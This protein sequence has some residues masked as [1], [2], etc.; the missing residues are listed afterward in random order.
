M[1]K[2]TRA[3][4]FAMV[5]LLAAGLT[6]QVPALAAVPFRYTPPTP[7]VLPSIP[8]GKAPAHPARPADP[9]AAAALTRA[10]AVAWPAAGSPAARVQVLDHA[11]AVAAHQ[12][13]LLR[14]GP[15]A[16]ASATAAPV[17]VSVDY[18]TFQHAYGADWSTRLRLVQ[19][20]ECA[21]TTPQAAGC[22]PKPLASSNNTK[23]HTVSAD[24]AA[25]PNTLLAVTAG[26]S[27]SAGDF[28]VTALAASS[29]WQAGGSSGD[30]TWSYP[31]RV[32]PPPAGPAPQVSLSYSAQS[33]DGHTAASNNQ[34]SWIG[35]GFDYQTG[36]ITRGY[37]AC[38]DDMG[39]TANNTT[40]TGD[41]CWGPDNATLMLAGHSG[42]LVRDD[43]SGSWHLRNDDGSRI[44]KLP[45]GGWKVTATDGTQYF[46]GLGQ[47]P[48]WTSGK[49]VTNSTWTV[50][51]FGN[52]PGEPCN[53]S[54]FADSWC[55]QPWQWNLD[56]VVDVH[57]NTMSYWYTP[58]TNNYTRNL[59]A[60]TVSTYT[61]GGHVDHIDYG[62]DN[63]SGTDGDYTGHAPMSVV[64]ATADR[65]IPNT[66][67]DFAHPA[68]WPD[69]PVDQNCSSTT[70]CPGIYAPTF[71]TQ[72]RLASV[73]TR[74]WDA[75]AA[76]PRE[77]E[78]W[79]LNHSYL[80]PGDT[81]RAGLWLSSISHTGLVGGTTTLP[82]IKF[83]GVQMANRVDT[84]TDQSPAMNW[85]RLSYITT[86]TGGI[87]GITYSP[88]ECVAGSHM[89]ASP[90]SN[91]MR[92]FPVYWTRP[93]KTDPT[94]DWFH[95]YVVREV[96]QTDHT[97]PA[98]RT[99]VA[100]NY[101]GTPAWHYS[102]DT[103]LTPPAR[104]TWADWRGYDRLEVTTGD[105]GDQ[106]FTVDRFFR[107][108]NGDHLASG[109]TR[110][111]SIDG[112]VDDEAYAGMARESIT[113]NGPNGAE[114]KE[115]ANRPWESAPT[116]TRTVAGTT[117]YA[118]HTGIGVTTTRT[119]LDGGRAPL[120]TTVTTTFDPTFG[121]PTQVADSGDDA[122]TDD[123][124]CTVNTYANNTTAWII[125]RTTRV[126]NYALPCGQDPTTDADVI[127]DLRTYY[128]SQAFGAAPIRGDV[129]QTDTAKAWAGP[130]SIT[131]MTTAKAGHDAAGRVTDAWDVRNNHSTTAYTPTL[132]GPVTAVVM[133]N[134][135]GWHATRNLE[136]AWGTPTATVDV[137]GLRTEG[138][139]DPLGRL[140][141]VWLPNRNRPG[142]DSAS[143][144]YAYTV[145]GDV[146]SVVA[147]A[148]LDP[149][150]HYQT[151]Y[152]FYDALLRPLQ[153]Q[154]PSATGIGRIL[155]DT[156]YDTAGRVTKANAPYADATAGPGSTW[157]TP[158]L[159]NQ[160]PSQTATG[161][162]G[163]GRVT[164]TILKSQAVE[165]WRTTRSYGG[166]HTDVTPPDGGTP[167]STYV[168]VRGHTTQLRQ[169]H[170]KT[171]A[172][173][174]DTTTYAYN[175]K[176]Q[177]AQVTDLA[178]NKW[179]W[180]Y[181]L[182]GRAVAQTDPD[183]GT[184]TTTY[185]DASDV[186]TR[187]DA[188]HVTLAYGYDSIGRRTGEFDTSTSGPQLAGW[189]YDTAPV[190]RPDGSN[191][192]ALGQPASSTRY[193]NGNP[194][195]AT[196]TGYTATY[197]ASGQT[198][199]I[200]AVE[201]KLAGSYTFTN[202]YNVDGS[203]STTNLP[204]VGGLLDETLTYV[205]NA[206]TGL[207]TK[208]TTNYGGTVGSYVTDAR[209]TQLG[210]PT[211]TTYATAGGKIAQTNLH[212][213]LATNRL[214]E[215]QAFRQTAPSALADA[216]YGYDPAGNITSI[217]DTPLGGTADTQCFTNDYLGRLTEAWT[218][219]SG[220]C[221]A[222][223]TTAGLGGP[224]PYWQ[225]WTL[226][227][228]GN[229]G[230]QTDHAAGGDTTTTYTYPNAGASQPH[231]VT[232][233]T[234]AGPGGT[235]N[236]S[237]GYNPIGG[238][239][240][241]PGPHGQQTLT[242]DLEG[243]LA[244][245]SDTSG[246]NSYLY[247]T[248]GT[249]L[250]SHDPKGATLDL[251]A[252]TLRLD[253]ASGT[254]S[255]T[256]YY[257]FGGRT[258]AQRTTATLS[259]LFADAHGTGQIAVDSASQAVTQRRFKPYG[260]P[261]GSVVPWVNDRG[262]VNGTAD[263]TGLTNI[264]ARAY[265]PALGRFISA[266]PVLDTGNPQ[267]IN[268]YS[269]ASD[270]PITGADPTGLM[271]DIDRNGPSSDSSTTNVNG[272][273]VTTT[274]DWHSGKWTV[275]VGGIAVARYRDGGHQQVTLDERIVDDPYGWAKKV[276]SEY[277]NDRKGGDGKPRDPAV[278]LFMAMTAAC[279]SDKKDEHFG[280]D[281]SFTA[282]LR[283]EWLKR[284]DELGGCHEECF[285]K[286][287]ANGGSAGQT[288]LQSGNMAAN[289]RGAA[290]D[291][292]KNSVMLEA[293]EELDVMAAGAAQPETCS[294]DGHTPVLMADGR[295]E[296]IDQVKLGDKLVAT[297]PESGVTTQRPVTALH[298][299]QDV[300]L[301][302]V[303]VT[304]A[305]GRA[306]TL[307]TTQNHRFWDRTLHAW[308]HAGHL[309]VGDRLYTGA[310]D[311][312]TV[313]AVRS[314]IGRRT[315]YNLTVALSHTYYVLAG[316][317]PVLVHNICGDFEL[318]DLGAGWYESP[319]HL[320]YGPS[321]AQGSRVL[322]VLEHGSFDAAKPVHS[323]FDTGGRGIL[324][325]VDEAWAMRGDATSIT[326]EGSRTTYVIPMGRQV[327]YDGETNITIV[328]Q[329]GDEV[330]T[331]YPKQ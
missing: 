251:G 49:P 145:S 244:T 167:T 117:V 15:A 131:W 176:G 9:G 266:D 128:D 121:Y 255:A 169:Y 313:T 304:D 41:E 152:Q 164:A 207:P 233:T 144:T 193:V 56:Y 87:I 284:V 36:A 305:H 62:T 46:F 273:A 13:V 113:D 2:D 106:T 322:H 133:T 112:I 51:V 279:V 195:S 65:C 23:S 96:T 260:E 40:K 141:A 114:V 252:E 216:H 79:T 278:A 253:S 287:E 158:P 320:L 331:A 263:P 151:A 324:E 54:T 206:T 31:M 288:I 321:S 285:L 243:H 293:D 217:A 108:M 306:S 186:L 214:T 188:R 160:I 175:R 264:G 201:G 137:N 329:N 93:G 118:R 229:R 47:L 163:A 155:T 26:P 202:A 262:Y 143:T 88:A 98:P 119:D 183:T 73:T 153:T 148:K 32:P 60:S 248:D 126:Q 292:V 154:G 173:A 14:V 69:T 308:V 7:Q 270:S 283:T 61:R 221:K 182:L 318:T 269:Y 178:G 38:A 208:L 63:R 150:G 268:G 258:V 107:G 136:P 317:V 44:E 300:A 259:W 296:P 256:R 199:S 209:Y 219:A 35:E 204:A 59:T 19:L 99:I 225:S 91:T 11:T 316:P 235:E 12:P 29:S 100:Y 134:S 203:L 43:A 194:Y 302:D 75:G 116:A 58:E 82:D 110:S 213:D 299:H 277:A 130:S 226:D 55:M 161:Y 271:Q 70:S 312:E 181:D 6:G 81:T 179:T 234:V 227:A 86:E 109:G 67:C 166:D 267:Q 132:G 249:R 103:G 104:R 78:R 295:S 72:K 212:Y 289:L 171:P 315:M 223:P 198:V 111:V 307:H 236:A 274:Y 127:S 211:V 250:I 246:A 140:T 97:G 327:G 220:D 42:E 48:G 90:D 323:V 231:T 224:A 328:V 242:W 232:A 275:S 280:C 162:D 34:P 68:N 314:F 135:L 265:D 172:G 241:R 240:S 272:V 276:A 257:S 89:P 122:R 3:A 71:W 184:G 10:P 66:T 95:K 197:A 129:T 28:T 16:G 180:T 18:S 228:T 92:C 102:P 237:Y 294:F 52:N 105:P 218:P 80:D 245:D 50:P 142:G 254:V 115:S 301:T 30:F 84:T 205:Y 77:V 290:S 17:H 33:V 1:R 57:G 291:F 53:K 139:Y 210:Q 230:T 125:G 123:D 261:R 21:L 20:P 37:K 64:F 191:V 22:Q 298:L 165:Q 200:P 330:I 185:N 27:G 76:A 25:A 174:S 170:G 286:R 147:T 8:E 146:P 149:N 190:A 177:L 247:T 5:V 189:T 24:V 311:T 156:F 157:F 215:A 238:T 124:R 168:D 222:A 326:H 310:G 83:T 196:V 282:A 159:D 85:W 297:D 39:G 239:T 4:T 138:S 309:R 192:P 94:V 187:T 45:N 325:T 281:P 303:T 74:V 319:N 120:T 101:P